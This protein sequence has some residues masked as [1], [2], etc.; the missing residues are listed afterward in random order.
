MDTQQIL[1]IL[2]VVIIV[3]FV[4][5]ALTT[6]YIVIE[7]EHMADLNR[8]TARYWPLC[9]GFNDVQYKY[10]SPRISS[11]DE[12]YDLPCWK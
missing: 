3:W 6:D 8:D 9:N 12:L 4:Y 10:F 2:I 11:R 5:Q 7:A 1:T